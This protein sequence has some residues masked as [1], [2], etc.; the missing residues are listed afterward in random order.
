[1]EEHADQLPFYHFDFLRMLWDGRD[2]DLDTAAAF[3]RLFDESQ[4]CDGIIGC[5]WEVGGVY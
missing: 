2:A 4:C 1:V 5:E 3:P